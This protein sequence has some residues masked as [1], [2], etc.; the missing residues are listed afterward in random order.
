M[1]K[2]Q[3]RAHTLPVNMRT[4]DNVDKKQATLLRE[5]GRYQEKLD[6]AHRIIKHQRAKGHGPARKAE[7]EGRGDWGA[8]ARSAMTDI[9]TDDDYGQVLYWKYVAK[10]LRVVA[11]AG[12]LEVDVDRELAGLRQFMRSLKLT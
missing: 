4:G 9:L 11:E 7:A 10:K 1:D 3:R 8:A 6:Q 12:A 5:L 2:M